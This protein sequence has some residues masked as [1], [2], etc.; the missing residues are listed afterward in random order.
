MNG[1]FSE[2]PQAQQQ[3]V[4]TYLVVKIRLVIARVLALV[5]VQAAG[6]KE[7][8]FNFGRPYFQKNTCYCVRKCKDRF[9]Y[10]FIYK[11]SLHLRT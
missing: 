9:I 6:K 1:M 2:Q 7:M 5:L 11:R 10:I 3:H 4:S 8:R